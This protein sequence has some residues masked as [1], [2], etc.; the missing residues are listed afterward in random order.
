M[1]TGIAVTAM[2][3]R[4]QHRNRKLALARLTERLEAVN[5]GRREESRK[6]RWKAH[7]PLQRGNAVRV[8]RLG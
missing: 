1:P 7:R 4:S 2:E 6:E 5:A 3:E 8:F